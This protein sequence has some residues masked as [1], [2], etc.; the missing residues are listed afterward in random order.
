MIV[1]LIDVIGSADEG[2]WEGKF[3]FFRAPVQVPLWQ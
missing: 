3:Y 2:S 1:W